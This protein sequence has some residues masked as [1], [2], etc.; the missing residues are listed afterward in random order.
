M[1]WLKRLTTDWQYLH[2]VESTKAIE[3][4]LLLNKTL[5]ERIEFLELRVE[6]LEGFAKKSSDY[7]QLTEARRQ[8]DLQKK[9]K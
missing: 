9:G 5:R 6:T 1:G 8:A 4:L 7:F 3:T 2:N